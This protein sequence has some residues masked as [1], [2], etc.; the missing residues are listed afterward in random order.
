MSHCIEMITFLFVNRIIYLNV[1]MVNDKGSCFHI[2]H[3][4]EMVVGSEELGL[5]IEHRFKIIFALTGYS[6]TM[7]SCSIGVAV[8][9]IKK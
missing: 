1:M 9:S 2:S 7:C 3:L 6:T 5:N 4:G 8:L